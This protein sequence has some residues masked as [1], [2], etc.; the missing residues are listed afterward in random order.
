MISSGLRSETSRYLEEELAEDESLFVYGL[1]ATY[2]FLTDRYFPWPFSQLYP[3]QAGGDGG[4]AL[5]RLLREQRPEILVWSVFYSP[6]MP[7]LA[8]RVTAWS[9]CAGTGRSR[10]SCR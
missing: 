1:D 8:P 3:G 7:Q 10:S 2:Y 6:G 5:V 9:T 4:R